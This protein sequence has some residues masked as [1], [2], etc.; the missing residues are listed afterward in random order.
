[1]T[2]LIR[3]NKATTGQCTQGIKP[4]G[5]GVR[6]L[7]R[8][9][10]YAEG[11]ALLRPGSS[12]LQKKPVVQ[13]LAHQNQTVDPQTMD[14]G[15]APNPDLD[16]RRSPT[17][18]ALTRGQVRFLTWCASFDRPLALKRLPDWLG[19]DVARDIPAKRILYT[20]D[21]RTRKGDAAN[22]LVTPELKFPV[23]RLRFEIGANA[24]ESV[25]HLV[26]TVMHEYR[27]VQQLRAG[28]I[29]PATGVD[30]PAGTAASDEVDAS[31]LEIE[32]VDETGNHAKLTDIWGEVRSWYL[33]L[34][35][36]ERARLWRRAQHGYDRVVAHLESTLAQRYW[37]VQK[38]ALGP[39]PQSE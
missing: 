14:T 38:D 4:A 34:T 33:R 27:H 12:V 5:P 29:D 8:G 16:R 7:L 25:P 20:K 13:K 35:H 26:S 2:E 21:L 19:M 36:Q 39:R 10:S 30:V 15:G 17:V 9:T 6:R 23:L 31:L 18:P 22:G 1:M 3:T 11:E 24:F 37:K 28:D 32:R